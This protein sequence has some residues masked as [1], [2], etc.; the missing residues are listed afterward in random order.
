LPYD[1]ILNDGCLREMVGDTIMANA[2]RYI[3]P[4]GYYFRHDYEKL[5]NGS[6]QGWHLDPSLDVSVGHMYDK[7]TSEHPNYELLTINGDG[8]WG[9]K[10]EYGG[11]W[12][13]S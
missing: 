1:L 8:K 11:L 13:K 3:A 6:W 4:G 7:F 10:C 9:F 5:L 2:D 12:R